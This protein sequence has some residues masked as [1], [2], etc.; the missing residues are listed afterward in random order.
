MDD[1]LFSQDERACLCPRGRCIGCCGWPSSDEAPSVREGPMERPDNR[2]DLVRLDLPPGY[3]D[4]ADEWQVDPE[5]AVFLSA[6]VAAASPARSPPPPPRVEVP[7]MQFP[8]GFPGRQPMTIDEWLDP[9]ETVPWFITQGPVRP[10]SSSPELISAAEATCHEFRRLRVNV[11]NCTFNLICV[12]FL[13][14]LAW[15]GH[16]F[17]HPLTR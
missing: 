3:I 2:D 17:L 4:V 6:E 10:I 13:R 5:Q 8:P 15:P 7:P 11:R 14:F 9:A 1:H 12:F 16:G